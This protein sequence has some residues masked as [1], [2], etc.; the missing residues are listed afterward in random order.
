MN[1]P[2]MM[3]SHGNTDV[4]IILCL[5]FDRKSGKVVASVI[6]LRIMITGWSTLQT[7]VHIDHWCVGFIHVRMGGN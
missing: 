7:S 5:C 2:L 4:P 6:P 1:I 3:L